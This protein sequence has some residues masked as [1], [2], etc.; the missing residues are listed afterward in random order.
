MS[1]IKKPW[2]K[3]ELLVYENEDGVSRIE[4]KGRVIQNYGYE[5]GEDISM[6]HFV[7]KEDGNDDKEFFCLLEAIMYIDKV[8]K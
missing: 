4:Y 2:Q 1:K 3:V 8:S 5:G 6:C 7:M